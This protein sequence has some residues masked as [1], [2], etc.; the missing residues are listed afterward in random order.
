[1]DIQKTIYWWTRAANHGEKEAMRELA[2]MYWQGFMNGHKEDKL[3]YVEQD[4]QKAVEFFKMGCESG[5]PYCIYKYGRI[6]EKGEFVKRDL[7]GALNCYA[8]AMAKKQPNASF[9]HQDLTLRMQFWREIRLLW[10]GHMKEDSRC[11]FARIPKELIREI[12]YPIRNMLK[13]ERSKLQSNKSE[14][15]VEEVD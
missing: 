3:Y 8:K 1:M 11:P 13:E 9:R 7:N 6:L 14:L 2:Q 10:I 4:K 5:Y 12:I 15:E